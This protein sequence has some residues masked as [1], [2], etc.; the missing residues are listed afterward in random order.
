MG[1]PAAGGRERPRARARVCV[2]VCLCVVVCLVVCLSLCVCVC[3]KLQEGSG[4]TYSSN[5]T[6]L[7]RPRLFYALS[8]LSRVITV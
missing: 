2:R 5:A 8:I 7:M 1:S 3:A 6:C 4:G